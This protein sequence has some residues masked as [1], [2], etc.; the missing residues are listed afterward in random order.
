MASRWCFA[1]ITHAKALGKPVFP[2][3]IDN[4]QVD[5]VLTRVQVI[6][7]TAGWDQAY[8]RLEKG[9]LDAGL[10]PKGIFDWDGTR[11]PYPGL[12]AFQEEDAATFFGREK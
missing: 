1:E 7:G 3:K 5:S 10:D 4:V 9:L 12:P 11:S 6:D 8:Q 2:I